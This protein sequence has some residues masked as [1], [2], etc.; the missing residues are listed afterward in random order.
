MNKYK[1]TLAS[2]GGTAMGNDVY[3]ENKSEALKIAKKEAGEGWTVYVDLIEKNTSPYV[4]KYRSLPFDAFL[5]LPD[6]S[7][8]REACVFMGDTT[9]Y[10]DP[11]YNSPPDF[12][13]VRGE[14]DAYY[15]VGN[16]FICKTPNG[17]FE[18]W[19]YEEFI[20]TFQEA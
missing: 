7:N 19:P 14:D 13:D 1:V 5:L 18:V 17:Y 6:M 16:N 8:W 12:L 11:E 4:K 2:S 15:A 20:K 10:S 9:D 3:A